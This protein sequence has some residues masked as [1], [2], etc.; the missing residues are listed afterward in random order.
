M[1]FAL[2]EPEHS[3]HDDTPFPLQIK[4]VAAN[5]KTDKRDVAK[6]TATFRFIQNLQTLKLKTTR[7]LSNL[8]SRIEV[9]RQKDNLKRSIKNVRV[10]GR[11]GWVSFF[12]VSKTCL[13]PVRRMR[14]GFLAT[15]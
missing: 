3:E 5:A 13:Q 11:L 15:F 10:F 9:F 7:N 12:A 4:Q 14:T 1:H 2:P 6:K 8:S